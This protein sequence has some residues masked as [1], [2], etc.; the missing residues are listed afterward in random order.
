MVSETNRKGKTAYTLMDMR[1][2]KTTELQ[3]GQKTV[4]TRRSAWRGEGDDT[5]RIQSF[6][7]TYMIFLRSVLLFSEHNKEIYISKSPRY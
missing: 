5:G 7:H 6:S 4:G 3:Q 1:D 2:L